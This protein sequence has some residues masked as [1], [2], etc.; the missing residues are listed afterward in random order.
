M[1]SVIL[2]VNNRLSVLKFLGSEKLNSDFPLCRGER[3]LVP[4]IPMLFKDPLSHTL[5]LAHVPNIQ[6]H[7]MRACHPWKQTAKASQMTKQISLQGL[8]KAVILDQMLK[9]S[10]SEFLY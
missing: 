5:V 7:L 6:I 10:S 8:Y 3:V 4:L 9:N 1:L 2:P